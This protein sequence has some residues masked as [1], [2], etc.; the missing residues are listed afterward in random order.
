MNVSKTESK[1]LAILSLLT[2]RFSTPTIFLIYSIILIFC[3]I[4]ELC[5]SYKLVTFSTKRIHKPSVY[6][7]NYN[8]NLIN[9]QNNVYGMEKIKGCDDDI[10]KIK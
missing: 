9:V 1:D 4:H 7:R 10:K 2:H 8:R 3:I 5:R 6:Q